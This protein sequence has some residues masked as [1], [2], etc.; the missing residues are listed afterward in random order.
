[1]SKQVS[2]AER[3]KDENGKRSHADK[4]HDRK[5]GRLGGGWG[6]HCAERG[7]STVGGGGQ[8]DPAKMAQISQLGVCKNTGNTANSAT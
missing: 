1:M 4:R 7:S 3:K 8:T 2:S 5:G 6:A